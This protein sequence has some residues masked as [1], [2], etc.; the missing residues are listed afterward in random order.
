MRLRYFARTMTSNVPGQRK[1]KKRL[2]MN[3]THVFWLDREPGMFEYFHQGRR[4]DEALS[5]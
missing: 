2:L 3:F 5:R 1:I 4:T